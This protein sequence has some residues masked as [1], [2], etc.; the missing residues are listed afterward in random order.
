MGELEFG[1]QCGLADA[2]PVNEPR[3]CAPS[4]RPPAPAH[5]DIEDSGWREAVARPGPCPY[6]DELACHL[7]ALAYEVTLAESRERQRVAQTLH[8]ELGQLLAMAQFKLGE[9]SQ[10]VTGT[11]QA[12][13]IEDLR[14]LVCEASKAA[15]VA[16]YELHTPLLHRLGLDAAV[17][18]LADRLRRSS[19]MQVHLDGELGTLPVPE[20]VL[21]VVFRVVREL[22]QNAQRHAVAANLWI[23]MDRDEHG[24]CIRVSDDGAGFDANRP[25][26][27]FGPQGGFGLFSAE[28]QMRAIGGRLDLASSP[29]QG[30]TAIVGLR[31]KPGDGQPGHRAP[32]RAASGAA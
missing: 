12:G 25:P 3:F 16:T 6:A 31:W 29:G 17:Q 5:P 19:T 22:A 20:G 24:L 13:R 1:K 8:D 21:S 32:L 30:T 23:R 27:A 11:G 26:R 10:A 2:R 15:R 28:A 18:G 14:L 7:Q 9:L 4:K